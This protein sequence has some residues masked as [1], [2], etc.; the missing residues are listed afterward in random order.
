MLLNFFVIIATIAV[1]AITFEE[2]ISVRS[3]LNAWSWIIIAAS[4]QVFCI[5][6]FVGVSA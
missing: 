5:Y 3:Q 2:I 4:V 6:W 1:W